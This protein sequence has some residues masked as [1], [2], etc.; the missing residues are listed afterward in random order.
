MMLFSAT[1]NDRV[2]E[3]ATKIVRNPMII[4]LRRREESLDYI[5]QFYVVCNDYESKYAVIMDIYSALTVGQAIIFCEVFYYS[6]F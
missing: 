4:R 1:Y 6:F 3:F 5:K 2:L